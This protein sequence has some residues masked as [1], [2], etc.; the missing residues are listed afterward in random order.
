M[1]IIVLKKNM[2]LYLIEFRY[3]LKSTVDTNI[4]I[5]IYFS[6]S[7]IS[8]KNIL[9]ESVTVSLLDYSFIFQVR[10]KVKHRNLTINDL[11][12]VSFLTFLCYI[13]I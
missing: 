8:Q 9:K 5:R 11:N 3:V 4:Y 12:F 10:L 6:F 2:F 7:V 13:V 1:L